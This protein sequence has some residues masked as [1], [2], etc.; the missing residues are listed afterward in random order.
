LRGRLF[1]S[2]DENYQTICIDLEETPAIC[3]SNCS[4]TY[5]KS[6]VKLP[7]VI[8]FA[9]ISGGTTI[10]LVDQISSNNRLTMV[11]IG[12]MEYVGE[13]R[14]LKNFIYA[15]IAPDKHIYLKSSNPQFLHLTTIKVSAIFQDVLEAAKLACDLGCGDEDTADTCDPLDQ[16]FPI[17][18]ELLPLL[19]EMCVK[20][21]AGSAYA[22]EDNTNNARDDLQSSPR[23]SQES[24]SR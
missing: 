1:N 2:L 21:L 11:P 19:T 24:G 10:S 8:N 20:E 9:G 14:F 6:T 23:Q 15:A 17:S 18:A 3:G 7:K 16:E 5:L 22:P 4:G 12:E 13:N